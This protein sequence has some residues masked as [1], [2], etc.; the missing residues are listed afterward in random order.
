MSTT[1]PVPTVPKVRTFAADL[2]ATRSLRGLNV[3]SSTIPTSTSFT[4]V[5]KTA[6]QIQPSTTLTPKKS[7][8][9]TVL[10]KLP[11]ATIKPPIIVSP[12]EKPIPPFHTFKKPTP[13]SAPEITT[14]DTTEFN[15]NAKISRP[16]VLAI[17]G[18]EHLN[19]PKTSTEVEGGTII[20]DTKGEKFSLFG[21]IGTSLSEWWKTRQKNAIARKK[22]KYTVPEADRRKGVIQKATTQT[23][24]TSSADHAAVLSRI[25]AAKKTTRGGNT[26]MLVAAPTPPVAETEWTTNTTA[27]AESDIVTPIPS[28]L[29]Q[30]NFA[31][32]KK[33]TPAQQIAIDAATAIRTTASWEDAIQAEIHSLTTAPTKTRPPEEPVNVTRPRIEP[34]IPKVSEVPL[35]RRNFETTTDSLPLTPFNSPDL[36]PLVKPPVQERVPIVTPFERPR[37]EPI[38]PAT[39]ILREVELEPEP[40]AETVIEAIPF[41]APSKPNWSQVLNQETITKRPEIRFADPMANRTWWKTVLRHTNRLSLGVAGVFALLL[42]SF[43]GVRAMMTTQ[44]VSTTD[45]PIT[46]STTFTSSVSPLSTT[47][48]SSKKE[49][50]AAIQASAQTGDSLSEVS[51]TSTQTGT[52]LSPAEFFTL[53]GA[54]VNPTFSQSINRVVAGSYRTA[55]WFVLTTADSATAQGGMLAWESNLSA[56]LAPW[57]GSVVVH[58]AKAGIT[59]FHDGSV[60]GRDVR[61]LTDEKGV[62][63]ITYGFIASNK[64][65]ITSDTATFLN[66]AGKVQ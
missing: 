15:A 3:P 12:I 43:V 49:L 18:V 32:S 57:F 6:V 5:K 66:L 58:S 35:P 30:P 38:I 39:K 41:P 14:I 28:I 64:L 53:L 9:P 4:V 55:P 16:S 60:T 17:P 47:V 24:R 22:P 20:T 40:I 59:L 26:S 19:V 50:V 42:I 46:P 11:V 51:L 65:L 48:V 63:R 33:V 8:L 56:S 36:A 25:K 21:A 54:T 2:T 52:S 27:T 31:V 23:G 1:T 29:N 45:V 61:I 7:P 62:E 13:A 34:I 44:R 37:I 10:K